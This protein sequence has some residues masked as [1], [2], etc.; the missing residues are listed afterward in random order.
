MWSAIYRAYDH[1]EMQAGI[2]QPLRLQGQYA[3]EESGLHYNRYRYYNPL[4]GRY[5]S[6]D[7][8]SIR[9]EYL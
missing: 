4:A 3:D 2:C 6:Q 8:I 1:T 5:I 7:P 9:F